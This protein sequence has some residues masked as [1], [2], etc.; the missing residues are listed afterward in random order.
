MDENVEFIQLSDSEIEELEEQQP[1]E[2]ENMLNALGHL[3]LQEHLISVSNLK[4]TKPEPKVREEISRTLLSNH[5]ILG[6]IY[7]QLGELEYIQ[8]LFLCCKE[9]VSEIPR[10]TC[11]GLPEENSHKLEKLL[12]HNSGRLK[13]LIV[14]IQRPRVRSIQIPKTDLCNLEVLQIRND[15]NFALMSEKFLDLNDVI[16][17]KEL[18]E[19]NLFY[20]PFLDPCYKVS[21]KGKKIKMLLI[22]IDDNFIFVSREIEKKSDVGLSLFCDKDSEVRQI[23]IEDAHVQILNDSDKI[24]VRN[25]FFRITDHIHTDVINSES[26]K[27]GDFSFKVEIMKLVTNNDFLDIN[28]K[29]C[30]PR[31][32]ENLLFIDEE[33]LETI[34]ITAFARFNPEVLDLRRFKNLKNLKVRLIV[35]KEKQSYIFDKENIRKLYDDYKGT[36]KLLH[37]LLAD[38]KELTFC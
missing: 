15:Y 13:T 20:L 8:N 16:K 32:N 19:L 2:F 30:L 28:S 24:P 5:N 26:Q 37:V 9:T 1:Q 12:D 4:E 23:V 21:I 10:L 27:T 38:G 11:L 3:N 22:G 14:W 25:M 6:H 17:K 29:I 31:V 34:D 36:N 33:K 18:C 35:T 7:D